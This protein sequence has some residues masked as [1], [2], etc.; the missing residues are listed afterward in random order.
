MDNT[1]A[2]I[3][4]ALSGSHVG[5]EDDELG[6]PPEDFQSYLRNPKKR[7]RAKR[8]HHAEAVSE[9]N[10]RVAKLSRSTRWNHFFF[11]SCFEENKLIQNVYGSVTADDVEWREAHD[12]IHAWSKGF[13]FE[14]IRNMKSYVKR[15][16]EE[17]T[18]AASIAVDKFT[19]FIESE[20]VFSSV[21]FFNVFGYM[22][23][24]LDYDGSSTSGKWYCRSVFANLAGEVRRWIEDGKDENARQR[25]LQFYDEMVA[26]EAYTPYKRKDLFKEA[27]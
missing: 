23:E 12:F 17:D 1:A 22:H 16:I 3:D 27:F 20:S 10:A 4:P 18:V 21:N 15:L 19:K 13:K 7:V 11:H 9:D 24:Y 25:L 5:A 8:H 14:T 2:G 6:R 26:Y